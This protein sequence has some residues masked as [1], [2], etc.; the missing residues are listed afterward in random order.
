LDPV[1]FAKDIYNEQEI[2]E[3]ADFAQFV[4]QIRRAAEAQTKATQHSRF[5]K[6]SNTTLQQHGRMLLNTPLQ[7]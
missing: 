3:P 6:G 5:A 7:W 1:N 4:K 2:C